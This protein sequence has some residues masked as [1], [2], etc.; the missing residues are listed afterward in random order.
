VIKTLPPAK[1]PAASTPKTLRADARKPQI[2]ERSAP[3]AED[4][5]LVMAGLD[6]TR[7]ANRDQRDIDD[8]AA[9]ELGGVAGESIVSATGAEPAAGS[10][11]SSAITI[12]IAQASPAGAATASDA[13]AKSAGSGGAFAGFVPVAFALGGLGLIMS[14]DSGTSAP[15]A[16]PTIAGKIVDGYISGATVFIDRNKNGQLDA[17]EPST[18]SDAQG[19]FTLPKGVEGTL[20]SVGGRD[21]STNLDFT[22]VMK[23]PAG[24][25]A[26]T[27]LTTLVSELM[28][29][30]NL[31]AAAAQEQVLDA[32][33]L[34][35]LKGKVDL[36]TLD[37]VAAA[38]A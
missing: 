13:S 1:S 21:I 22:G 15:A 35:A 29:S 32:V 28:T 9:L 19:N 5:A 7:A 33:G 38:T 14:R 18:K 20:V 26:V 4:A 25:T 17:D 16:T 12:E 8:Q 36:T 11:A 2:D 37:P 10:G 23:A 3:G 30:R 27:P 24:S 34:S 31:S 6:N